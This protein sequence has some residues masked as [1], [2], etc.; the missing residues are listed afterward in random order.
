[1]CCYI[2]EALTALLRSRQLNDVIA[3]FPSN[4]ISIRVDGSR[5]KSNIAMITLKSLTVPVTKQMNSSAT[6]DSVFNIV[7]VQKP[8][9]RMVA[10]DEVHY[11]VRR[12]QHRL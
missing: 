4:F 1:M 7:P 3:G 12:I 9:R 5:T 8:I 10:H 6:G 2:K 11:S